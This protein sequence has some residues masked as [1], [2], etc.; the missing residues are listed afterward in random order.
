MQ[1]YGNII[2]AKAEIC[3]KCGVR[4]HPALNSFGFEYSGKSQTAAPPFAFLSAGLEC[5]SSQDRTRYF[6][7]CW[8]FIPP[9]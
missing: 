4:E 7:F 8:A 6:V 3:P 2:K 9:S 1:R 5:I